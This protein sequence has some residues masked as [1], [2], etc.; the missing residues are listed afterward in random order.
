MFFFVL[1]SVD[2]IDDIDLCM[3]SR[4]WDSGINPLIQYSLSNGCR[5]GS[6]VLGSV[7][8]SMCIQD[9]G[10]YCLFRVV[11]SFGVRGRP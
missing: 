9:I 3:L 2:C 5:C 11:V 4:P 1:H 8:G 7:L 6:L 10:A